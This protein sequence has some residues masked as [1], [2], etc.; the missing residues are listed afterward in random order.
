[1]YAQEALDRL[2]A[3]YEFDTVVDYGCGREHQPHRLAFGEAGKIWSGW[4]IDGWVNPAAPYWRP[5]CIWSSHFLEHAANVEKTLSRWYDDLAHGGILAI[6]VPP[7]KH[8]IVGGHVNLFN[9]GLLVYRLVLAG[10][11]CSEAQGKVYGYNCSVI[12]RKPVKDVLAGITLSNGAGD[13][14]KLAHLFPPCMRGKSFDGRIVEFNWDRTN[15]SQ[16]TERQT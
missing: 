15:A 10:F 9:L 6:T 16:T 1:M 12:V 8:Q 13:L 5:D 14:E 11:D 2:L 7:L 4:D 3:E